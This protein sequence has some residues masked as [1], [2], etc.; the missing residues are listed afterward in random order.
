M[1]TNDDIVA[2]ARG[3]LG[4]RFHHQ[5]RIK[6]TQAHRGGVDC[7]G[8]LIGVA[9]ELNFRL[10]DGSPAIELDQTDY[11]HYP[12]TAYLQAQLLRA[13]VPIPMEGITPGNILLL[14]IDNAPQHLAI[15][16]NMHDGLGIIHAYAP[17][18]SVVEHPFD[19]WWQERVQAAFRHWQIS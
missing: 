8:L 14:R 17:A 7:L 6:R 16:S 11:T 13:L 5:G 12:D 15:V 18:R 4:T 9:R 1:I 10:P 3:W 19:R 2:A